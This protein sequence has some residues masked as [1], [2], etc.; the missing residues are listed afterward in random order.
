M[1][2]YLGFARSQLC[3]QPLKECP[4]SRIHSAVRLQNDYPVHDRL[5]S[6][7]HNGLLLLVELPPVLCNMI[8]DILVNLEDHLLP[9]TIQGV[10]GV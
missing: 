10:L 9:L 2:L 7:L 4:L 3:P 1:Q 5:P 8:G 6:L